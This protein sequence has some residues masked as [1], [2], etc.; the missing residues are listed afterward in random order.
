[1]LEYII[2]A[3]LRQKHSALSK[4]RVSKGFIQ[5]TVIVHVAGMFV[6]KIFRADHAFS[7]GTK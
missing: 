7:T 4:Q 5:N 2:L 6:V 3:T 1:M